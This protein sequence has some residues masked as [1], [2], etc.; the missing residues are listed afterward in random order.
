MQLEILLW[1]V[2]CTACYPSG[3][4]RFR[5][6]FLSFPYNFHYFINSSEIQPWWLSGQSRSFAIFK[7]SN[8]AV[9]CSCFFYLDPLQNDAIVMSRCM[10]FI[11]C[12]GREF[13]M[14]RYVCMTS[15]LQLIETYN[16]EHTIAGQDIQH[17][18]TNISN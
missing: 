3:G 2:M 11:F 7:D 12:R 16:V 14:I 18:S 9:V 10:H 1:L 4:P 8:P 13:I 15:T 5:S 17:H 6:P